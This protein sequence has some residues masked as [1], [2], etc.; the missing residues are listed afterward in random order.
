[1]G[2]SDDDDDVPDRMNDSGD[3]RPSAAN[4]DDLSDDESD[5]GIRPA[6]SSAIN[7]SRNRS[8]APDDDDDRGDDS[9]RSPARSD[10]SADDRDDHHRGRERDNSRERH[11]DRDRDRSRERDRD[12][13]MDSDRRYDDDEDNHRRVFNDLNNDDDRNDNDDYSR[14]N[15]YDDDMGRDERERERSRPLDSYRRDVLINAD[16]PSEADVVFLPS[17]V[18]F[19]SGIFTKIDGEIAQSHNPILYRLLPSAFP[20]GTSKEDMEDKETAARVLTDHL[21]RCNYDPLRYHEFLESNAKLVI[22]DDGSKSLCI[23]KNAFEFAEDNI[24]SKHV[25]FR[26]G[27]KVQN[28]HA[29]VNSVARVQ[30]STSALA[31]QAQLVMARAAERAAKNRSAARTMLRANDAEKSEK[32]ARL[33]RERRERERERVK[34]EARRRNLRDKQTRPNRPLTVGGLESDLHADD[35]YDRDRYRSSRRDDY[36]SSRYDDRHDASR[37]MRGRTGELSVKR[38]KISG[39][40][41]IADDEEDSEDY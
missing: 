34:A 1:M 15:N 10:R 4:F 41:H 14:R 23:G 7:Y 12:R 28:L 5:D 18:P 37:L 16:N 22:W 25:V 30:H 32:Q 2:L 21:K 17:S 38:R 13:D 3:R 35:D 6:S 39:S 40:R 29:S 31:G 11:R 24:A 33:D 26:R 8:S 9:P 20:K 27:D 36:S 19:P